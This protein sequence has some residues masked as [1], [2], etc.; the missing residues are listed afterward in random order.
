M[1]TVTYSQGRLMTDTMATTISTFKGFVNQFDISES[2]DRN[3]IDTQS[4]EV[5]K[6]IFDYLIENNPF[7]NKKYSLN[8]VINFAKR[9]HKT[10]KLLD[11]KYIQSDE[12]GKYFLCP[13]ALL[14]INGQKVLAVAYA[15][16]FNFFVLPII[17]YAVYHAKSIDTFFNILL[18][19][20]EI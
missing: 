8:Q 17:E 10:L 2:A 16:K 1:T 14:K 19:F 7:R 11:G 15:G 3:I 9:N 13:D 5:D 18:N 6:L 4:S 12:N 20:K